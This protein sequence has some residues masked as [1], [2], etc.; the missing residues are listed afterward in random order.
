MSLGP[1]GRHPQPQ[2]RPPDVS[3]AA[4]PPS[5]ATTAAPWCRQPT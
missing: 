2:P 4:R 1:P 3:R 5:A